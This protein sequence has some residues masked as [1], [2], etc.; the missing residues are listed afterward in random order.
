MAGSFS[1]ITFRERGRGSGQG[2]P[3]W[4][5][6]GVV[7]LKKIPGS[8][9]TVIQAIGTQLPRLG[10]IVRVTAAQLTSLYAVVGTSATLVFH[11]ETTTA[12]LE[13]IDTPVQMAANDVFEATLNL[14]RSSASISTPAT[15]RL[16]ESGDTRVTE[17][18]DP[19]ITE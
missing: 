13:S 1:G 17:S 4:S 16:T 2:F 18:G 11:F 10:L 8:G 19:R 14:I 3:V 12:R 7:V 5:K 9:D 6:A 15:A